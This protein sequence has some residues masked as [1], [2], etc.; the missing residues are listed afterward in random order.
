M[1][2]FPEKRVFNA[3]KSIPAV[4]NYL[5]NNFGI[6]MSKKFGDTQIMKW[7][8][9]GYCSV[10][11]RLT[12][13]FPLSQHTFRETQGIIDEWWILLN[14]DWAT[15]MRRVCSPK[16]GETFEWQDNF[17]L[18]KVKVL[19]MDP[20]FFGETVLALQGNISRTL[21]LL[22]SPTKELEMNS[23]YK[24]IKKIMY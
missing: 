1:F 21:I 14:I 6:T 20:I 8:L 10:A 15:K 9:V 7:Y 12:I 16:G 23:C 4:L 22:F 2:F 19:S 17:G 13:K 11:I 3:L 5:E 24:Q 18:Q